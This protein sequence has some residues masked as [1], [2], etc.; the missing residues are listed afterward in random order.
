MRFNSFWSEEAE[1]VKVHF[2]VGICY[3]AGKEVLKVIEDIDLF[4]GLGRD[5]SGRPV[6]QSHQ[7]PTSLQ[8]QRQSLCSSP[9]LHE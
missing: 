5:F 6:L 8:Y 4:V 7:D 2:L 1:W 9:N 3:P